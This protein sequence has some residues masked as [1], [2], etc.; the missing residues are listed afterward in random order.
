V[1]FKELVRIMTE[2]DLEIARRELAYESIGRGNG[3]V[4]PP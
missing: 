3:S 1:R 2:A 4:T